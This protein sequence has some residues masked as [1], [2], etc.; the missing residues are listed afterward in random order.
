MSSVKDASLAQADTTLT[1]R[2]PATTDP[3]CVYDSHSIK[4]LQKPSSFYPAPV[5]VTMQTPKSDL[6]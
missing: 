6:L 5:P 2:W 3:R 4:M 1:L